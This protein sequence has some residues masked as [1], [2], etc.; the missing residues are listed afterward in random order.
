M[1]DVQG[2]ISWG[3]AYADL[4]S[5][6]KQWIIREQITAFFDNVPLVSVTSGGACGEMP[7]PHTYGKVMFIEKTGTHNLS[8]L[9]RRENG[10]LMLMTYDD[11]GHHCR[12]QLQ[13][14]DT[15]DAITKELQVLLA[16]LPPVEPAP[17]NQINVRFWSM[18]NNGSAYANDRLLDALPWEEVQANYAVPVQAGI[19]QLLE[20][21]TG[22]AGGHLMLMYGP[23]GT[24]KTNTIR[25]LAYH[26][27]NWCHCQYVVDP[28]KFFGSA[29]YMTQV[30]LDQDDNN[31]EW[32]LIIIE[33][34][35]EL[36]VADA[37]LKTGQSLGRLLNLCDGLIGQGLKIMVLI[38]TNEEVGKMHPAVI[39]PGRCVVNMHIDRLSGEDADVWRAAHGLACTGRDSTLAELYHEITERQ[40]VIVHTT[41]KRVGFRS[42]KAS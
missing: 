37:K 11:H 1:T 25:T 28:E 7:D 16:E 38:T 21:T 34:A 3:G 18:S 2:T 4:Y 32:R 40:Q 41:P 22:P 5:G 39:R 24:G 15:E 19:E 13:S 29:S 9:I 23:A 12:I 6:M 10:G 33:D 27:K 30:L 35:D 17:D 42:A 26:W 36:L 20:W 31:D 14:T 8:A